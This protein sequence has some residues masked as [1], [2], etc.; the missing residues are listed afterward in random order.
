MA[1]SGGHSTPG[2]QI[3]LIGI[4]AV[5]VTL[6]AVYVI[7]RDPKLPESSNITTTPSPSART[8]P[9]EPPM[10]LV[11]GDSYA[12]GTGAT[13]PARRWVDLVARTEGW[14]V[15]NF[16]RGGTGYLTAL[17]DG[18]E[19][20]GEPECPNYRGMLS[21]AAEVDP[22]IVLVSGGRN[23]LDDNPAAVAAAV[24][25]FYAEVRALFP[26]AE[27]YGVN[28]LWDDDPVPPGLKVMRGQVAAALVAAD[29]V[30]L[31]VGQPLSGRPE[32][33]IEDGVHPSDEG[34]R[35]IAAAV[36]QALGKVG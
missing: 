36:K 21:L 19:A 31:D 20:C 6:G 22:D 30:L 33:V 32:M 11:V 35:A 16:A 4:L 24:D 23:D 28:P 34:H 8:V 12:A 7:T 27:V 25:E 3:G 29:G 5:V 1:R 14:E 15:A 2:W 10:V 17:D 13:E 18:Q 9:D 26:D